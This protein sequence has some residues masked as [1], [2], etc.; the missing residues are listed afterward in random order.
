MQIHVHRKVGCK[1][2]ASCII[3]MLGAGLFEVGTIV[4]LKFPTTHIGNSKILL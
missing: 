2:G 1:G 4:N 3:A